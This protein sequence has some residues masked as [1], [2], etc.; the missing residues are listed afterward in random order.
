MYFRIVYIDHFLGLEL[1]LDFFF[2]GPRLWFSAACITMIQGWYECHLYKNCIVI[3]IP[4]YYPQAVITAAVH[5]AVHQS[6]R[7][8]THNNLT[9]HHPYAFPL[10]SMVNTF[11]LAAVAGDGT[12]L[13]NVSNLPCVAPS[14]CFS[15][16]FAPFRM[17]SSLCVV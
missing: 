2:M 15:N 4:T 9:L 10:M 1:G 8:L 11:L 16:F 12:D 3:L 7:F 17:R 13:K 14:L 5:Y 6:I